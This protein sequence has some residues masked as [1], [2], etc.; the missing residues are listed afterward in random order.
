M[1]SD[2]GQKLATAIGVEVPEICEVQ[3]LY[4][5]YKKHLSG[6][7]IKTPLPEEVH[8]R[9]E[10][11]LYWIKLLTPDPLNL[12]VWI[13]AKASKVI[14]MLEA[15]NFDQTGYRFDKR[16][17]GSLMNIRGLLC[18]PNCIHENLRKH[19]KRGQGG[20]RGDFMYVEYHHKRQRRV[21]FTVRDKD[22][23]ANDVILVSSFWSRHD[24]V[25]ICAHHN[26]IYVRKGSR[27]A[28][29]E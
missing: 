9:D 10:N 24:W 22:D 25:K 19:V 4:I 7:I 5:E 15:G 26:A 3:K 14:P 27:C 18:N 16:R 20:I 17:A 1:D 21:A 12:N 6:K 23:P 8:L 28:C 29:G 11:F 2:F 13:E